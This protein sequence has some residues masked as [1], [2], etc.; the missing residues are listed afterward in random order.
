MILS[1]QE[2]RRYRRILSIFFLLCISLSGYAQGETPNAKQARRIF[3]TAY[4]Q[5]FGSE[6]SSLVYDVNIVGLFKTR[7]KIWLKN[8][9]QRYS[10][11]R[12]DSWNDGERYYKAIKKKKIVEIYNPNSEN[13]DKYA[14]RFKFTLD[15]FNYSITKQ[16]DGLLITLKQKKK[17]KGTI[18][19]VKALLAPHTYAPIRLR[20][21]VAF[22]WTTIKISDF[23]AGGIDDD[24]FVF[25]R[26]K[27]AS[28]GW[29]FED[30]D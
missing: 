26:N 9:K 29:K 15:D 1:F 16:S 4:E 28:E 13:K 21:K 20:I 30:K 23:H 18:K 19:E 7:G 10:D 22:I 6:G 24:V 17:A 8:K 27:Y 25:P 5:V 12:V 2:N 3:E 11:R 14:S